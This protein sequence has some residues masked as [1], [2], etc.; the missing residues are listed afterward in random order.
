MRTYRQEGEQ[1][2]LEQFADHPELEGERQ[3]MDICEP[4]LKM[5]YWSPRRLH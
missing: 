3:M 4:D 2:L 5:H 1:L